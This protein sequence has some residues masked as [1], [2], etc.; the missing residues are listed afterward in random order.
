MK[1]TIYLLLALSKSNAFLSRRLNMHGLDL[2][3]FIILYHLDHAEGQRLRRVDLANKMG[4]TASGITRILLP[5]EKLHIIS[6]DTNEADD[7]RARYA[8]LTKAGKDLLN[9]CL[10]TLEMKSEDIFSGLNQEQIKKSTELLNQVAD[11]LLQ[12][13][14]SAEAK[15]TWGNTQEYKESVSR[16]KK[17]S[18]EDIEII[19]KEGTDL[20]VKIA[21]N[22]I[23]GADSPEVQ[24]LISKHYN[25]LRNFYEPNLELYRDLANMYVSDPRFSSYFDKFSP[26]MARFMKKAINI[27]C[28][29]GGK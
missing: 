13:E 29:N 18:K 26:G 11:N 24:K 20:M 1:N 10:A 25:N 3:D 21:K 14:Y 12:D 2:N 15:N 22:I 6:R 7:A 19:K 4:L 8:I 5:L 23:L 28:D 9:D 17:I 16:M 27:F